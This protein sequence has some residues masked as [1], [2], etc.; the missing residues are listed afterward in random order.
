MGDLKRYET[1]KLEASAIEDVRDAVYNADYINDGSEQRAKRARTR[2][3][4]E[5][6]LRSDRKRTTGVRGREWKSH[7]N[8]LMRR[9]HCLTDAL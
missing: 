5:I 9:S 1:M 2:S 4:P 6:A 3:S 8:D 7:R